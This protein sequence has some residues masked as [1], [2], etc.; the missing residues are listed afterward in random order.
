MV[1]RRALLL[2]L[3][4][5]APVTAG[6]QT[7]PSTPTDSIVVTAT[8]IE[9]FDGGGATRFGPLEFRGGLVLNSTATDFGGLSGLSIDPDGAGF[10]AVT[11]RGFWLTGRLLSEGDRPTGVADARL[12]PMRGADGRT[13]AAR[14]RGD[15]ESLVRT[16]AGTLVGIE[17]RQEVWLFPGPDPTAAAGRRLIAD[18]ALAELGSN[19]GPEAML[20][21]PGGDPAAVIVIAEES[22]TDPARLP[23]FLFAPLTK[24][25]L[26]G[27]FALLRTDEF[28]ATDA[29]LADDGRVYLLER[30]FD[31]LRGVAMR[32]RRFPLAEI[33]PGA[34]I[35]GEV[36]ITAN[37]LAA[38]D[39]MEG[40]ALHRNA[41]GELILTLISD[42]NFSAL[43]RTLLL[44]FVVVE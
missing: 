32:I 43:Q 8:P 6:A 9:R 44:R 23:G 18:P 37:R 2:C 22:P 42:D 38:I 21:P 12:L 5:L 7:T 13:L 33:R 11:D 41:A 15:V 10:L 17:R 1:S 20:A 39:N 26:T 16:P 31:L 27:R 35:E 14:G 3:V 30:R 40:L 34:L 36:L 28:S 25:V 19:E 24:P 29:A 4:L